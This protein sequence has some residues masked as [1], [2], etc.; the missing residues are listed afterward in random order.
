MEKAAEKCPN[1]E[2]H[3]SLPW[4]PR[5]APQRPD[6]T[7]YVALNGSTVKRKKKKRKDNGAVGWNVFGSKEVLSLDFLTRDMNLLRLKLYFSPLP[8][9]ADTFLC[10]CLGPE[11]HV[12]PPSLYC[13]PTPAWHVPAPGPD[14]ASQ[15]TWRKAWASLWSRAL[16]STCRIVCKRDKGC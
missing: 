15:V 12:P 5:I 11:E 1:L 6:L 16:Q 4:Q 9:G 3:A 13:L 2:R 7:S 8:L 10:T 14:P